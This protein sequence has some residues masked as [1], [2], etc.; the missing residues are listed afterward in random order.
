MSRVIVNGWACALGCL[1]L[2]ALAGPASASPQVPDVTVYDVGVDGSDTNNIH[3]WGQSGGIAAY[4]IATQSCNSGS[5]QV[6]WFTSG[7]STLHP[8]IS[9]N[10]FRLK[11][12]RFEHIGQSWLKH[13]FCAVNEIEAFCAPCQSTPC[14]TLGIGCADTYWATLNDGASGQS[15]RHVNA[16]NG[17]HTHS[18]GPT[19][20]ATIRGRL[21]VAVTDIDPAQNPG[22][23]YFIEGHYVTADDAVMGASDNNASWRRVNVLSVSNIDGGGPTN[24]ESPAIYAWQD[25]DPQVDIVTVK[26]IENGGAKTSFYLG[27]RVTALG[28]GRWHYEYAIQNLNSDQ[29][30]SSLSV[31]VDPTA[32]VTNIGFHDV[33]YHSGDPYDGTDWPGVKS[34]GEVRWATVP[35]STNANANALRWG[36]LYNFRFDA[37]VPP[38]LSSVTLGLFKPS[39]STNVVVD[40]VLVPMGALAMGHFAPDGRPVPAPIITVP[41]SVTRNG[42]DTN[43]VGLVESAP[44]LVGHAWRAAIELD[45][46]SRSLLLVSLR[47]PTEGIFTPLG[48]V[49]IQPPVIRVLSGELAFPIPSDTR[50][51]GLGFSAQAAVRTSGGWRLTNALDVTIGSSQ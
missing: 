33:A 19:G 31:P 13:G 20:N 36:T 21:Q 27:F 45:G 50:L 14:D 40:D 34:G 16:A 46:V 32:L 47:G 7:G 9:Q 23:E 51:I 2:L 28:G 12:G 15:K 11:N 25:E 1:S 44:A 8:V 10:M 26:N 5:E 18:G 4:S 37:N 41:G 22:G 43:P 6:D 3:Y 24:R 39:V 17:S 30:G 49:L 29:S 35:F 42:S 38:V 48:E